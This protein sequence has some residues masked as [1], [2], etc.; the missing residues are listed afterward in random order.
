MLADAELTMCGIWYIFT[1]VVHVK[2]LVS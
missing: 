1:F 2:N